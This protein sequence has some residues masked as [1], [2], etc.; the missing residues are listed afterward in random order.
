MPCNFLG[1]N[2]H[3]WFNK[4]YE[5]ESSV[6]VKIYN[7]AHNLEFI[8][9]CIGI[10]K[11]YDWIEFKIKTYPYLYCNIKRICH[12]DSPCQSSGTSSMVLYSVILTLCEGYPQHYSKPCDGQH[13][14]HASCCNHQGGNSL[15]QTIASVWEIEEGGNHNSWGNCSQDKPE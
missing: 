12:L 3:I 14:I 8:E 13:I 1:R 6:D 7:L 5:R 11:K 15:V 4:K 2:D 9:I 10:C